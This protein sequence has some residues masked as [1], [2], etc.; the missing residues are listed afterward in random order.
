MHV[1]LASV[2]GFSFSRAALIANLKEIFT[3]K[4]TMRDLVLFSACIRPADQ[5][6]SLLRC[7]SRR[8]VKRQPDSAGPDSDTGS[9]DDKENISSWRRS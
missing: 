8:L 7:G 4:A 9:M 3:N 5:L 6:L 2:E 1:K